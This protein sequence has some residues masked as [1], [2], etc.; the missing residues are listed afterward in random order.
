MRRHLAVFALSA[1][2]GLGAAGPATAQ[3]WV[4][5]V[6]PGD[7]LWGLCLEYT[8]KQG[9]W[10]EL[11]RYNAIDRDRRMAPGTEIRIPVDWLLQVPVAGRV[12]NVNGDVSYRPRRD[13]PATPLMAGQHVALGSVLVSG[14]GSARITLGTY[15][16]L[17]LRPHSVLE[18]SSVGAAETGGQSSQVHLEQGEVEAQVAPQS[19]S[20]FEVR[21]PSA[22]AAVRGTRYRVASLPQEDS[23]R[24]EVL[25]GVVAVQAASSVDVPA[26]FGV[27]AT[28]GAPVGAPR[29]L[30]AAPRFEQRRIDAPLPVSVRWAGDPQAVAWQLDVYAAGE[31]GTL[32]YSER[33]TD[34]V[35]VLESLDEGCYRVVARAI[36][37]EGFNGLEQELPV[38]V[39]P[40]PPV[41]KEPP[42]Y[43]GL[44]PW[45]TTL[46]IILLL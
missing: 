37:S 41:E 34:P 27:K 21:T 35:L 6:Q 1:L 33:P 13:D 16:E 45:L 26:G 8:S 10:I 22:I 29:K 39:Q 9:C 20:R 15:G 5:R 46:A 3:D 12:L 14:D 17:L 38:C 43:W 30:L 7:T 4:Y 25:E 24:G 42:D 19:R 18:I 2:C 36:D 44:A 40:P 31:H 11:A 23:T 32:L 28:A